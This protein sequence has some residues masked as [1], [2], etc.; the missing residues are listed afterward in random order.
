MGYEIKTIFWDEA[1][2]EPEA[3]NEAFLAS[4]RGELKALE[5]DGTKPAAVLLDPRFY[6]GKG[7][8]WAC[9][10]K[11]DAALF[12]SFTAAMLHAARRLK[13]C[14][15]IAGFMLPDFQSD[16]ETL[17]QAG[18]EDSCVESFKAAFAKKHG[19][20]EFV[21]RQKA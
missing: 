6:S 9:G 7:N 8:F 2:S 18:L 17:A 12:E 13:D 3:Y 1:E 16:W 15:A 21:R 14:A 5:T 11:K 4:L 19:H 20:Y 10:E